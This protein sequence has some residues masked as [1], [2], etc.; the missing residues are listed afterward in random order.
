MASSVDHDV[1]ARYESSYLDL[2]CLPRYLSS[3]KRQRVELFNVLVC[4]GKLCRFIKWKLYL[5]QSYYRRIETN[6]PD[7]LPALAIAIYLVFF[8][9][10]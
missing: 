10:G 7:G 5:Y 2:H 6:A 4:E 3:L 1:M 9:H 8:L